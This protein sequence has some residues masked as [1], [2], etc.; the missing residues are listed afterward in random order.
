LNRRLSLTVATGIIALTA[1]A[2]CG[3]GG[4]SSP[5]PPTVTAVPTATAASGGFVVATTPVTTLSG[6]GG[7]IGSTITNGANTAVFLAQSATTPDVVSANGTL[8]SAQVTFTES[9]G[10]SVSTRTRSAQTQHSTGRFVRDADFQRRSD[11]VDV[12]EK[13]RSIVQSMRSTLVTGR[14]TQSTR[15]TRTTPQNFVLN[16]EFTFQLQGGNISG[17]TSAPIIPVRAKLISQLTHVNVWLDDTDLANQ[18]EFFPG[19]F[20]A[21]MDLTAQRFEANYLIETAAF[22]PATTTANVPF[23][24]CDANGKP[25]VPP[26]T[27]PDAPTDTTGHT[28]AQMNVVITNALAGTG[29]GGYFFGADMLSQAQ[30]NCIPGTPKT[31][32]NNLKMFV[33]SSDKYV[34]STSPNGDIFPAYNETFWLHETMPQTMAHEYQHYLHYIN[35]VLQQ[36]VLFGSAGGTFD[37]SYIDEGCSVLAQDLVA[38]NPLESETPLFVHLFLIEPDLYSLT[39]FSGYQPDPGSSSATAPYGYYH[40]NGGNYG[41]S[42][43][44]VRYLYDRFGPSAIARIYAE[45]YTGMGIDL[46]P[47][48]QAANGES[49]TKLYGEFATAVGIHAGGGGTEITTDPAYSFSGTVVLRGLTQTYSRRTAGS[50]TTRFIGQPGPENPEIFVNNQPQ[51]DPV[52]GQPLRQTLSPGQAITLKLISGATL[53]VTPGGTPSNGAT[54]RASGSV[55]AFQ[56]SLSQGPIPT[57]A[58]AYY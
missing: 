43:L 28:D 32:V 10:Q 39:S 15:Q 1:L 37:N 41:L 11:A 25:L 40:N 3:G 49:F 18:Q 38:V 7:A 27:A 24:E 47:A 2:A 8:A 48:V 57:P 33:M 23:S 6:A 29:E 17:T 26:A 5:T 21:D 4:G 36:F 45:R 22:G 58:P 13:M 44:F 56:G 50:K 16:Q 34:A 52:S 14:S 53:F 19:G 46:G 20:Q 12:S 54:L 51:T 35:K 55:P 9:A 30:A 31:V 42:Y